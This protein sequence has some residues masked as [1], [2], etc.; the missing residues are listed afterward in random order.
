MI[1]DMLF[2]CAIFPCLPFDYRV[3]LRSDRYFRFR[4]TQIQLGAFFSSSTSRPPL[5]TQ[6]EVNDKLE[7]LENRI[8]VADLDLEYER[9]YCENTDPGSKSRKHADIAFKLLLC[10]FKPLSLDQLVVAASVEEDGSLHPEVSGDYILDICSNFII[11]THD[12]VQ[13]AHA[14]AREYL[15]TRK[16]GERKEFDVEAQHVQGALSSLRIVRRTC[17]EILKIMGWR[18]PT[19]YSAI[20][21]GQGYDGITRRQDYSSTLKSLP[22]E[23]HFP[24][25]ASAVWAYHA[26]EVSAA[27]RETNSI[28]GEIAQF[29]CST[30]FRDWQLLISKTCYDT[31]ILRD[32]DEIR[33]SRVDWGEIRVPKQPNPIFLI[34]A[35]GFV[36]C[37]EVPNIA[38]RI[39]AH[40]TNRR[41]ETPLHTACRFGRIEVV[42]KFLG[43][44]R[45]HFDVNATNDIGSTPLGKAVA[46]RS[47]T[48][49][50]VSLLLQH[51]V[52]TRGSYTD[53]AE[54]LMSAAELGYLEV[55]QMLMQHMQE[56]Y[57]HQQMLSLMRRLLMSV[58]LSALHNDAFCESMLRKIGLDIDSPVLKGVMDLSFGEYLLPDAS[59]NRAFRSLQI[60]LG[61]NVPVRAKNHY[62]RT[63]LHDAPTYEIAEYLLR[64]DHFLLWAKDAS[65]STVYCFARC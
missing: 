16:S 42:E 65:E 59:A 25:Y 14:S 34:S 3:A 57:T 38:R 6:E 4:W 31:W 20:T 48:I 18:M 52:I 56:E 51:G 29:L 5:R 17:G 45:E 58:F 24:F 12:V 53:G 54:A 46:S 61:F 37:L 26:A 62:G 41:A 39:P 47:N 9:V 43:L 27:S 19:D 11:V 10:C 7:R 63:A 8:G 40:G 30:A 28:S 13:F 15:E 32:I 2:H 33:S 21:G 64:Q 49:E 36:E 50:I 23:L 1:C 22:V 60:L 55:V 44:F 35:F